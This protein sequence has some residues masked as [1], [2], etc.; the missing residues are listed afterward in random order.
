MQTGFGS[1]LSQES[2]RRWG[3]GTQQA[4]GQAGEEAACAFLER[5]GYRVVAR[6]HQVRGGE[7]DLIAQKGELL[8]FA[9]VRMRSSQAFA[10][11]EATVTRGKQRKVV[12]A[13]LDWMQRH[14]GARHAIRFDVLAVTGQEVLHLPN[15]FDA[16]M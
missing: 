4:R 16:G 10:S 2:G 9:E 8:V 13:A 12:L 11:P 14:G 3:Q 15:A 7:V 1:G 5:Q 6:N